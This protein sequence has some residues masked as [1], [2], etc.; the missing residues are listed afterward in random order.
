MSDLIKSYLLTLVPVL[1]RTWIFVV[2]AAAAIPA[3]C[4]LHQHVEGT[5]GVLSW[6]QAF[7]GCLCKG[8]CVSDFSNTQKCSY[9]QYWCLWGTTENVNCRNDAVVFVS[10]FELVVTCADDVVLR[11]SQTHFELCVIMWGFIILT[12]HLKGKKYCLGSFSTNPSPAHGIQTI[13]RWFT[14]NYTDVKIESL[15][16][17]TCK[18]L[19]GAHRKTVFRSQP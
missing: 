17:A 19:C 16:T 11:F 5:E 4:I 18:L 13:P 8:R 2:V 9:Y 10:G 12:V 1:I 6:H 14:H 15:Q 3:S 7:P